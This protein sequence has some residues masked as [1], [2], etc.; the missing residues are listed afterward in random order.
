MH[1]FAWLECG[2]A[3]PYPTERIGK[4]QALQSLFD[5][6][7]LVR[8]SD[9]ACFAHFFTLRIVPRV[10]STIQPPWSNGSRPEC[11]DSTSV[12]LRCGAMFEHS[13]LALFDVIHAPCEVGRPLCIHLL[14][15]S[16][17]PAHFFLT[18]NAIG[19]GKTAC[20]RRY[21]RAGSDLVAHGT[22]RSR[23]LTRSVSFDCP[24]VTW[25]DPWAWQR[26][27]SNYPRGIRAVF[28]CIPLPTMRLMC[29]LKW[30]KHGVIGLLG[31]YSV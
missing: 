16:S 20:F 29:W 10:I 14:S 21:L 6:T 22:S 17:P 26:L 9:A 8:K 23:K 15:N 31:N 2:F 19:D 18:V 1:G 7:L 3:W 12:S 25:S 5:S 4:I 24:W 13:A 28:A 27:I 30:L 11:F